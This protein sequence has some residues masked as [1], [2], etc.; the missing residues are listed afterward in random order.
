MLSSA[1]PA[2]L[3]A[4]AF[5]VCHEENE[6]ML[7]LMTSLKT[8]FSIVTMLGAARVLGRP[9]SGVGWRREI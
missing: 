7:A 6:R 2:I 3:E 8:S 9:R 1:T 4:N 5:V